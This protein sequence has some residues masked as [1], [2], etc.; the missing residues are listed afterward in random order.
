VEGYGKLPL[1]FEANRGQTDPRVKLLARG[2]GYT[3]FLT[4]SEAVLALHKSGVGSQKPGERRRLPP[5]GNGQLTTD[6]VL[7]MKLV[8]ANPEAVVTGE[9][10]LPGKS[11]YFIGNDPAKWRTNVA[12]Y[13]RVKYAGVYPGV[14][15]LYYGNQG[16]LEY[17]LVVAPGAD[18]RAIRLDVATDLAHVGAG[19]VPARGRRGRPQGAPLRIDSQ[20]DLVVK[21]GGDE[22]RFHKPV[23][24]QPATSSSLEPRTDK[25]PIQG[26]YKLTGRNQVTFEV[27]SYDRTKPLVI[28]PVLSYSTF[29]GGSN[30][31]YALGIAVDAGGNAYVTGYSYST[32]FPTTPGAFQTNCNA[33]CQDGDAFVTKLNPTGSALLYSTY[34]GGSNQQNAYGIAVDTSGDAFVTGYTTSGD[35]PTTAGAYQTFCRG[36]G[37]CADVFLTKLNPTG[38]GLIYSTFLGGSSVNGGYGVA[39]D[40]AGDAYLTGYTASTDFPTTP[41]AF[42]TVYGGGSDDA[43]ITEFNTTG[44]A[45]IYSTFL[46]GNGQDVGSGIALDQNGDIYAVGGTESTNFPVSPGAFQT[47]YGGG[48]DDGYAAKLS[49]GGA[50]LVY[51]TYL[52]GNGQDYSQHVAADGSGDAYV[53]GYSTSTNYPTTPGAFQTALAG[54]ANAVVTKL[55]PSG[56][57]LVYSTYLGGNQDDGGSGIALDTS[58]NA[59]ITGNTSST[60][61]PITPGAFQGACAGCPDSDAFVSEFNSTGSTLI[62]STFLGGSTGNDGADIALDPSNNVYVSGYTSSADFPVTSGA[63]QTKCA[64]SCEHGDGFISKFLFTVSLA[65]AILNFGNQVVGFASAPQT[66]T[67]TNGSSTTVVITGISITGSDP[68]DFS[69]TDTCPGT[70]AAGASCTITVIFTPSATGTRTASL[71]VADNASNSPQT[72]ALT[73]VGVQAAVTFSSTSLTFPTQLVYT[74]SAP[75]VVTLTNS[76][77]STL[78]ITSFSVTGNFTQTNTCGSSLDPRANCSISVTFKP[79]FKGT[80]T[81]T[82]SVTDNAPGSPQ[83]VSLTGTGTFVE[84]SPTSL[85]FGS[86][87]VGSTSLPMTITL[88]NKAG[89]SLGISLVAIS[90]ADPHDFAIQ[91]NTCGSSVPRGSSCFI[92][93]TF[94]PSVKG[95]RTAEVSVIDNGGGSPQQVS[96]TGLGTP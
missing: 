86:Q 65:P 19:L 28:D 80:L 60:N 63:F 72:L 31:D 73:G 18:P 90:G 39:L 68:A 8:D 10:Q 30:A 22:L 51:S 59:Y 89:V 85:N 93:V 58:G 25:L 42:Q 87:P 81:G 47:Q 79:S 34:L 56:T 40:P 7:T 82:V 77:T 17:D 48:L 45:V 53:V 57:A 74:Q 41:G 69:Q 66:T 14:D 94:T 35:F 36:S 4:G 23:I 20:G 46:G 26:R 55:N 49:A 1:R 16:Q 11:N 95:N 50:A 12:N 83:T 52:G 32:N 21:V 44:S 64:G 5:T 15:L 71:S 43:F 88:T 38:S 61:F 24:Y 13:G 75:R 96:V 33:H 84:L 54:A 67:L 29:L 3:L 70:L 37:S 2:S 76:G 9:G 92:S 78:T 27:G 91:T 62:Y 6:S